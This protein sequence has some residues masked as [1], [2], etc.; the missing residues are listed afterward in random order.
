MLLV[1]VDSI[2]ERMVFTRRATQAATVPGAPSPLQREAN[3]GCN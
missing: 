2:I 3:R 1:A